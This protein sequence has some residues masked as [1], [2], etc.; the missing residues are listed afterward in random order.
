ME[1]VDR[2]E[3]P[4]DC[5]QHAQREHVDLQQAQRVEI[6]LV[7]LDDRPLGHCCILDRHQ[8]RQLFA[9]DDEA[10]G[11]LRQ[12]AR[13]S[14]HRAGDRQHL[15]EDFVFRIESG[16]DQALLQ[17][18]G[19]V[20]PRDR[21]R[22]TIDLIERQAERASRIAQCGLRSI[23]DQRRGDRRAMASI[24]PV[25]VLHH[26]FAPLMLEVDVD[27][28]GLVPLFRHEALEQKARTRRIDLGDAQAIADGGVGGRAAPLAEDAL[29]ACIDDDVVHSEKKRFGAHVGDERELV[30]DRLFHAIGHAIR[31]ARVGIACSGAFVRHPSQIADRCFA[32]G[33]DLFR[34]FVAKFIEAERAARSDVERLGHQGRRIKIGEPSDAAQMRLAVRQHG[35]ARFGKR[36]AQP[37]RGQHVVQGFSR[38]LM[39][40]D[41]AGGDAWHVHGQAERFAMIE[42]CLIV[43]AAQELDRE[44]AAPGKRALQPAEVFIGGLEIAD[45]QR[46]AI[47]EPAIEI[48]LEKP[49]LPFFRAAAGER[50]QLAKIAV[51]VAILR[52]QHELS[53]RLVGEREF[54]ADDQLEAMLACCDVRA[55]HSGDRALV[56]QRERRI[57]ECPRALDQLVRMRGAPQERKVR[58]TVKL[59]V[60]GL[61]RS[62][63]REQDSE[64]RR[65]RR[66][67][68]T[69]PRTDDRAE[70]RGQ[71]RK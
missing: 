65:Q 24:L 10:A 70:D 46:Q 20:P 34:I 2:I 22:Q 55:D 71:A 59:G 57:V 32:G 63:N 38:S 29:R 41:A 42:Q 1:A 68:T 13:K 14:D 51:A 19:T 69:E 47:I 60:T 12:V 7:P 54:G 36:D 5:R 15:P 9:R 58:E 39:K 3:R 67:Q 52:E 11:V 64:D 62:E 30:L 44:P 28:G 66:G 4:P 21:L 49:V 56:G 45:K 33:H 25:D 37:D 8:S 40:Q 26:D 17:H 61:H 31:I 16:L 48:A 23:R 18:R 6:I 50:D 53:P 43:G 27:V 35:A